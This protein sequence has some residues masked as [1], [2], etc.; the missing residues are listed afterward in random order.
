MVLKTQNGLKTTE[1][2]PSFVTNIKDSGKNL[3][4]MLPPAG[5]KVK[6]KQHHL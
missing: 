5:N 3:N 1:Q 2:R 6:V 4:V